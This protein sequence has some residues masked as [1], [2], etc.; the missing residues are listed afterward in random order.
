VA[1]VPVVALEPVL[2][3]E[4]ALGLG[5]ERVPELGLVPELVRHTKQAPA[6][7]LLSVL[8]SVFSF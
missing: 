2:V 3:P 6:I 1:V 5:Q 7:L 8:L 4:L